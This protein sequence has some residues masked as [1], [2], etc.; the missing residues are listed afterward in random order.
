MPS[1][2][3]SFVYFGT[4]SKP[5]WCIL[6]ALPYQF[7]GS[8]WGVW[9]DTPRKFRNFNLRMVRF[10][11]CSIRF[12]GDRWGCRGQPPGDFEILTLKWCILGALPYHLEGGR[13][14]GGGV[15]G[16]TPEKFAFRGLFHIILTDQGICYWEQICAPVGA[17][18][19]SAGANICS[20]PIFGAS[21]LEQILSSAER[22]ICSNATI[23]QPCK[24]KITLPQLHSSLWWRPVVQFLCVDPEMKI[25]VLSK[26]LQNIGT[27]LCLKFHRY[28]YDQKHWT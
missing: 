6:G 20:K 19:C 28:Q 22:E 21:A 9:G 15:W 27:W 2:G 5:F 18:I 23:G 3:V 13:W 24:I 12:S 1:T 16:A 14:G 25:Y 7:E 8:R 11:G 10:G 26:H 17:S 4:P